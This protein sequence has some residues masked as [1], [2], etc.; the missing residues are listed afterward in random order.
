MTTLLRPALRYYGGKWRL[1]PWIIKHFPSHEVYVEPFGGALSVLLQKPPAPLEVANDLDGRVVNF[2]RVLRERP[3]DLLRL[4][5]L[6]PWAEAEYREAYAPADDPLEDARRFWVVC[7][8]SIQ[9]GPGRGN[10]YAQSG[11]RFQRAV[12]N[13]PRSPALDGIEIEHLLAVAD[14]LKRVQFLDRDAVEVVQM[15]ANIANALLYIDPPYPA[16]TR[17]NTRGYAHEVDEALYARLLPALLDV[18]GYV[19]VSGYDHP[20]YAPLDAAGWRRVSRLSQVNGSGRMKREVLWLSPRTARA[21]DARLPL[22]HLM[23]GVTA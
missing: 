16:S 2:F 5:R 12:D 7:W 13:R 8:M 19:V 18:Q 22:L 3:G 21:L 4:I 20:A 15:Y 11:F 9:G 6:T 1:A 23:Q 14:R 10:G 17:S